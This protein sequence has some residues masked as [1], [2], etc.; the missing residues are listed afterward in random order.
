M[1]LFAPLYHRRWQDNLR[2]AGQGHNRNEIFGEHFIPCSLEFCHRLVFD[3]LQEQPF[4]NVLDARKNLR[5]RPGNVLRRR[6]GW[7]P[8]KCQQTPQ[9][10]N[11]LILL[12]GHNRCFVHSCAFSLFFDQR[13]LLAFLAISTRR[14]RLID[15]AREGPPSKPPFLEEAVLAASVG[16]SLSHR[17]FC[18]T[19]NAS[20][21]K[22]I[23]LSRP[24]DG[25]HGP[26]GHKYYMA[27]G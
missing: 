26:Y 27:S 10:T 17:A 22:S 15:F 19:R 20:T 21:F 1:K 23:Q 25:L 7:H 2:H 5:S 4:H 9:T 13:A 3:G 6:L 11:F 18:T 12:K 16:E 24:I 14:R 8:H